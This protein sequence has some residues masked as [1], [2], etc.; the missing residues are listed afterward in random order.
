MVGN[1]YARRIQRINPPLIP[2]GATP[3]SR[4]SSH[5]YQDAR[6]ATSTSSRRGGAGESTHRRSQQGR[7]ATI[8]GGSNQS[9]AMS[10]H[11]RPVGAAQ[12]FRHSRATPQDARLAA[13]SL[14]RMGPLRRP[15]LLAVIKGVGR[16]SA[17][18][19]LMGE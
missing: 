5:R 14:V 16:R 11:L 3:G 2:L 9:E 4:D 17:V 12:A 10:P 1:C 6:C 13:G 15:Q 8:A 18:A 19:E 7:H